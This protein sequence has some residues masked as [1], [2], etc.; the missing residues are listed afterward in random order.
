MSSIVA[1]IFL[2]IFVIVSWRQTRHGVLL[3]IA[4]LPI[5]LW[6]ISLFGL[7]SSMLEL[8]VVTLFIIWLLKNN[9]WRQINLNFF[10]KQV[11]IFPR[12]WQIVLVLWLLASIFALAINPT[13]SSLGLWRAYF[14]EPMFFFIVLSYELKN[15][16]QAVNRALIFLLSLLF[17]I[18]IYQY[19]T[20]WNLT[21]AYNW[22]QVRRLTAL[23]AYP[24][25]LALLV[26]PLG[27]YFFGL[28]T[29]AKQVK[30]KILF[31]FSFVMA[32]LMATGAHSEGA[33]MGLCI[34]LFFWLMLDKKI[35][36]FYKYG[37]LTLIL[38]L[39]LFGPLK[40][41][42][43]NISAQILRPQLNLSASSL[44]IRSSQWREA[45]DYLDENFVLGAGLNAYQKVIKPYHKVEWL[46]VY[47]YPHNIFLNFWMEMGLLGLTL[48]IIILF[49]IYQRLRS[50][51]RQGDDWVWPLTL[52]WLTWFVH[53]LVD[54]PYFKNDLSVLFFIFL[55]L[56]I[57]RRQD[58]L[59]P[60][61]HLH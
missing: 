19:F 12:T 31:F 41:Y 60:A 40:N 13:W 4:T 49:L 53:G 54:A 34:A 50:L 24:N 9:R 37:A 61:S 29:I 11:N 1:L 55:A 59:T 44:E 28:F 17:I 22:P 21:A 46:E 7:P 36:K 5:Y 27:A 18:T 42:F 6:R 43:N 35:G 8:M 2:I 33:I 3:I 51:H 16:W 58:N 57:L 39:Y 10:S 47:L 14:L 20:S 56:T 25:A 48:F 23:Y 52:F 26:T 45:L 38:V 15:N 32:L 30:Q